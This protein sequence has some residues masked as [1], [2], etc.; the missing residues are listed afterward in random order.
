MGKSKDKNWTD[1]EMRHFLD[2]CV[3]YQKFYNEG[4][5][6]VFYGKVFHETHRTLPKFARNTP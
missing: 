2:A 6:P 5:F 3:L 1:E 4:S